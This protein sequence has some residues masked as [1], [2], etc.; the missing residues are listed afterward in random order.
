MCVIVWT[1]EAAICAI[2]M[3]RQKFI[4]EMCKSERFDCEIFL[5]TMIKK[6]NCSANTHSIIIQ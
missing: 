1:F 6:Y 4:D 3:L 5:K 2:F